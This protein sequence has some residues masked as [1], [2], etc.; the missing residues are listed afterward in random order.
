MKL[1][2]YAEKIVNLTGNFT[3]SGKTSII[4]FHYDIKEVLTRLLIAVEIAT[5]DGIDPELFNRPFFRINMELEKI[6]KGKNT[7][8][9]MQLLVLGICKAIVPPIKMPIT[10]GMYHL[11]NFKFPEIHL[12]NIFQADQKFQA[13]V[14]LY[15]KVAKKPKMFFM[16]KGVLRGSIVI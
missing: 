13:E 1:E 9:I 10:K 6:L 5:T 7:N 2:N 14:K 8:P 12:F 11:P 4:N 15:I 16:S 3:I